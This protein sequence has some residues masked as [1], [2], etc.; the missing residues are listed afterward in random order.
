MKIKK[1]I[2]KEWIFVLLLVLPFLITGFFWNMFPAEI[3][4]IW[5]I[6]G[7]AGQSVSKE[8]A[9]LMIPVFNIIIYSLFYLMPQI[10]PKKDRY[11]LF[12]KS[13]QTLRIVI[14]S[15]LFLMFVFLFLSGAFGS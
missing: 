13:Y 8:I 11:M 1:Y 15:V 6:S 4:I 3:N 7:D 9:L 2:E 10:Y 14:S 5:N 12:K